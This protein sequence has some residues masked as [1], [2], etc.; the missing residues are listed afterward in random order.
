MVGHPLSELL[1]YASLCASNGQ[2]LQGCHA[3]TPVLLTSCPDFS[4]LFHREHE[5]VL[6]A[7]MLKESA[8]LTTVA[9]TTGIP[10]AQVFDFYNACSALGLISIGSSHAFDPEGYLL[11]LLKKA[12]ADRKMLRC[13]LPGQAVLFIAPDTG[14]YYTELDSAGIATLCA[15]LLSELEVSAVD[16]G[17]DNEEVVQIGRSWVRRKKEVSL[18]IMPGLPHPLSELRFRAALYASQGRL[19]P[20]YNLN[21]PVRLKSWPDKAMLKDSALIKAERY[22]FPL[23][24]FMVGKV[25]SLPDIAEATHLP[26][27]RVI[28]FHNACAVAGLLEPSL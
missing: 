5:P 6:A 8:I 17:G 9:D 26:L 10:L 4:Q 14:N 23:A 25:V 18:P 28:D 12:E 7:F 15:A 24:A 22:F 27:A 11:G 13:G 16:N 19:L 21:A 1:W 20:G 2:L 3:D